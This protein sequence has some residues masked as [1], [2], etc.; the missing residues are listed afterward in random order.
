MT[1]DKLKQADGLREPKQ[2][3]QVDLTWQFV[4]CHA[5]RATRPV[6]SLER[7]PISGKSP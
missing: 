3:A 5:R 2:I 1:D 4:I 7:R 6:S